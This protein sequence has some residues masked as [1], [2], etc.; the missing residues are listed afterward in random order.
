MKQTNRCVCNPALALQQCCTKPVTLQR[1][2][3]VTRAGEPDHRTDGGHGL[4]LRCTIL[5]TSLESGEITSRARWRP[6]A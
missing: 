1:F 3:F 5:D 4:H 2:T 6:R